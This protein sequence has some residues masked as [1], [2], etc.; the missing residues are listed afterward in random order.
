MCCFALLSGI[1]IALLHFGT[2]GPEFAWRAQTSI[3]AD[4]SCKVI[5]AAPQRDPTFSSPAASPWRNI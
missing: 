5:F 4:G 2:E 1:E 3:L